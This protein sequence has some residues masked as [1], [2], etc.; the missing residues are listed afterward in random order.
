MVTLSEPRECASATVSSGRRTAA[1][2]V[3]I[4]RRR[5]RS[6]WARR[7]RR[8]P[9]PASSWVTMWTS[10]DPDSFV[11]VTPI[12]GLSTWAKRPRRLAPSTSWVAFSARAKSSSAAGTSSPMT[13]W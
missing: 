3:A 8:H 7:G 1:I 9:R 13:W 5:G 11:V 2:A 6:P 4:S 10:I 12:P